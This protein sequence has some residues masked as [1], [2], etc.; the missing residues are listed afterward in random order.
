MRYGAGHDDLFHEPKFKR[1]YGIE[2]ID[3][4]VGVLVRG[5][6]AECAQWIQGLNRLLRLVCAVHRLRLVD[7]DDGSRRLDELNRLPTGELVALFVDDVALLL[8]L[9]P[10]EILAECVDIDDENLQRVPGGE[11][12]ESV[13]ALG[14]KQPRASSSAGRS[15]ATTSASSSAGLMLRWNAPPQAA[16]RMSVHCSTWCGIRRSG[17][18][19]AYS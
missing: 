12:A 14:V 8:G 10:G 17:M 11:L 15:P 5:R 3:Q 2:P 18:R 6:V 1:P 13:D 16:S 9:R 19:S 7:D 4:I